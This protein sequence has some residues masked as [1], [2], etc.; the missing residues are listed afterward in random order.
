[1]VHDSLG[2]GK[3]LPQ[4]GKYFA[5]ATN[6]TQNSNGIQQDLTGRVQRK[7]LYEATAVVRLFGSNV[8]LSDVRVTLYVQTSD[9]K[10]RYI[11]I[12]K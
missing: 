11:G 7:H 5:S 6:R 1:V 3:V 2:G 4:I 10:D 8:T 9:G 12:A